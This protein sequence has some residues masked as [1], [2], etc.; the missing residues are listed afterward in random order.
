MTALI[1]ETLV[2]SQAMAATL[3][4]VRQRGYLL[5][6]VGD[7]TPGFSQVN[8]D[9]KWS[10]L[11][12]EFC[13][14]LAAA[15]LGDKDKVRF[16]PLSTSDRFR[17]LH[18]GEI[19]VLSR[20]TTW[21][22]SREMDWDL[23]F[24]GVLFYDG[25]GFLLRRDAGISS[26]LELSGTSACVQAGEAADSGLEA[27]VRGK[28]MQV[29]RVAT[30]GWKDVV[31][32]YM[33][34]RCVVLTGDLSK[35]AMER[36]RMAHWQDHVLLPDL[37]T[38][39]PLGPVVRQGDDAWFSIVRWTLMAMIAAEEMELNSRNVEAN[40]MQS[41]VADVRRLLGAD[42]NLGAAL[43][44]EQDWAYQIVRQVGNYGEIFERTVG[45][46]SAWRLERGLNALWSKGGLMFAV[47]LR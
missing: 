7:A 8:G 3:D 22:F 41:D 26:V 28:H 16:R 14:A 10:G 43:G 2:A 9:G 40:R 21:T 39:E 45:A 33:A 1:G 5:C 20:A 13:S 36:S 37:V 12:V 11:D 18:Q 19:D 32:A 38:K 25:Q 15:V 44:L 17:A 23:R 27:F 30:P 29:D 47:P 35:L 24:A 34:D 4:S 46:K 6:G 31:G 42:G